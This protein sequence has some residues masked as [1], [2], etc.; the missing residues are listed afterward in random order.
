MTRSLLIK[1]TICAHTCSRSIHPTIADAPTALCKFA[2][3]T[4]YI[5]SDMCNNAC[6][7]LIVPCYVSIFLFTKHSVHLLIVYCMYFSI[8]GLREYSLAV[9]FTVIDLYCHLR[10]IVVSRYIHTLLSMT[11]W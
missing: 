10:V 9:D 7:T 1:Q 2:P 8:K 5:V 6:I 3:T 4:N 11:Y